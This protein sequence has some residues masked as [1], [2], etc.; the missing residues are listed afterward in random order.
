VP[1]LNIEQVVLVSMEPEVPSP[2]TSLRHLGRGL[3]S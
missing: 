3:V 2:A 1:V